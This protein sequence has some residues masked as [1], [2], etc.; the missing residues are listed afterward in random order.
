MDVS[1]NSGFSP[2][3]I[4]F[5]RVF[6]CKPSILGYPYFWKHPNVKPSPEDP[7]YFREFRQVTWWSNCHID[8]LQMMKRKQQN[9]G[10]AFHVFQGSNRPL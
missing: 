1:E 3:I 6:H 2:P 5:N 10:L 7:R 4:D 8:L 9:P